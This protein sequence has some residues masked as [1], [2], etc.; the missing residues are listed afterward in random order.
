MYRRTKKP[1]IC[2]ETAPFKLL[3]GVRIRNDFEVEIQ[4]L[5]EEAD[6]RKT[7]FQNEI[8]KPMTRREGNEEL[9]KLMI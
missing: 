3:T 6:L 4:E 9:T 1:W 7:K 8:E 5:Q 2:V